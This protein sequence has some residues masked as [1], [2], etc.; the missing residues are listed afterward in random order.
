MDRPPLTEIDHLHTAIAA[1]EA[2]R[3]RLG[4]LVV[5]TALKPVRECL[6]APQ[7][8]SDERK[9]LTVLFADVSGFTAINEMLH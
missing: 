3:S 5:N 2:Q 7:Y 9:C 1:L 6:Q 4:D 8:L